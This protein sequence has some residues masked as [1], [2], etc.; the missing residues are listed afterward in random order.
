MLTLFRG[1]RNRLIQGSNVRKYLLYAFGEIALVVIGILIALQVNNWN[2]E[3]KERALEQKYLVRLQVDLTSDS[4]FLSEHIQRVK[5]LQ[6]GFRSFALEMYQ[7]QQTED[8]FTKLVNSVS[9]PA[10]DLILSDNT[11]SEINSSGNLNLIRNDRIKEGIIEYYRNYQISASSIAQMNRSGL[12][13]FLQVY[14]KMAKYYVGSLFDNPIV[15][16][17]EEDWQFINQT[18]SDHFKILEA[19]VSHYSYKASIQEGSYIALLR[20][21]LELLNLVR[22]E[23]E[24]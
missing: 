8:D 15:H 16:K 6:E 14:P 21:A 17:D 10:N 18:T 1:K 5:N 20:K 9:W 19:S 24:K 13:I 7:F 2:E 3:R 4:L 11:Y 22:P 23:L 12:D